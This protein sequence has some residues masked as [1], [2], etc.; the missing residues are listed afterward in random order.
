MFQHR[1]QHFAHN[2]TTWKQKPNTF[3][4]KVK[5]K[6]GKVSGI[7]FHFIT[8]PCFWS[9]HFFFALTVENKAHNCHSVG[10]TRPNQWLKTVVKTHKLEAPTNTVF[11]LAWRAIPHNC[12]SKKE[13]ERNYEHPQIA[14]IY[15]PV[16]SCICQLFCVWQQ[17][18]QQSVFE[19]F[20][21][22]SHKQLS[23]LQAESACWLL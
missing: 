18:F 13:R 7:L 23:C 9:L 22:F 15:F 5:R 16:S 2:S 17:L 10:P 19:S 12:P 6:G 14:L 4:Q 11:R 21:R 1:P 8:C 20:A 3:S